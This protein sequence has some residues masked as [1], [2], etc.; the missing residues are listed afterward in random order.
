M[1]NT[2]FSGVVIADDGI[3]NF[4]K[5]HDEL[6]E[7]YQ[8]S[9]ESNQGLI[10]L[11]NK[12]KEDGAGKKYDCII[13]VSGGTDSSYLLYLAVKMGL[14]PLAVHYDNT[15]NREIASQNIYEITKRLNV[16]LYTHVLNNEEGSLIKRAFILSEVFE[17]DADSDIAYVQLMRTQ[18][19][20]WR[21]KYILEGHSFTAEGISPVGRAYID[22]KYIDT[23]IN[24][25]G[26]GRVKTLPKMSFIQ[27]CI[28]IFVYRQKFVRPLWYLK[29]EKEAAR[30]LLTDKLNWKYYG[31]HHLENRASYFSHN[32]WFTEKYSVDYRILELCAKLRMN[33]IN[34]KDAEDS[35]KESV[36]RDSENFEYMC[37]RLNI[38]ETEMNK[39]LNNGQQRSYREFKTYKKLFEFFAPFFKYASKRQYV[40]ESFYMKYCVPEKNIR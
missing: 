30:K 20:K 3:C 26:K 9:D 32:I 15:F 25:Y 22:G 29:Y 34:R 12:I 23:I 38:A 31:G 8:S 13:G 17:F 21:T 11:F 6:I 18:A 39:I 5:F 27:F 10:Q 37:K 7:K 16:D 36:V 1:L 14:R 33:L 19:R 2:S 40:S 24:T 35:L 28:W 4:C